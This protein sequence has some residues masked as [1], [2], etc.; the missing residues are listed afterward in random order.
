MFLNVLN[1]VSVWHPR[2]DDAKREKR[3]RNSE[4]GHNIRVR[5][6]LPPHGLTIEPLIGIWFSPRSGRNETTTHPFDLVWARRRLD[7]E[8]LDAYLAPIPKALPNIRE[9]SRSMRDAVD[10]CHP[11]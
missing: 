4:E 5:N 3:L 1:N 11:R 6:V 8:N 10:Y 2:A 9:S 7:P